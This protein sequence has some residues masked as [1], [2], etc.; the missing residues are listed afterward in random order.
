MVEGCLC[1]LLKGKPLI[2]GRFA[3]P[4]K[5]CDLSWQIDES[6]RGDEE[7][8][9]CVE[10]P[11]KRSPSEMREPGQAPGRIFDETLHLRGEPCLVPGLSCISIVSQ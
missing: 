7:R 9:L 8:V 1:A 10:V 11:W 3:H 6:E 5:G 4:V 2:F